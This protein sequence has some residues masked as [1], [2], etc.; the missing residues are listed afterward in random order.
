MGKL[1]LIKWLQNKKN[2]E[3]P[4]GMRRRNKMMTSTTAVDLV[5]TTAVTT[6]RKSLRRP[7]MTPIHIHT[8]DLGVAMATMVTIATKVTMT[9]MRKRKQPKKTNTKIKLISYPTRSSTLPK[10]R[11][12]I[13]NKLVFNVN[14]KFKL[15]TYL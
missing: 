5:M 2:K 11:C 1:K 7:K 6:T 13:Y 8:P 10:F 15:A 12:D 3:G 14:I 9:R 4:K